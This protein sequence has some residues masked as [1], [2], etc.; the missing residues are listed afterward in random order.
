MRLVDDENDYR[1]GYWRDA[2]LWGV[3][4][5]IKGDKL[6]SIIEGH[7]RL[8]NQELIPITEEEWRKVNHGAHDE[9][10]KLG[11]QSAN[12]WEKLR[13]GT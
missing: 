7:P 2:G 13:D 6:Y 11:N 3:G 4:Y 10:K 8:H 5:K 12:E 1:N 9:W